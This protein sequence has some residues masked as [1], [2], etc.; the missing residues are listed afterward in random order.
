MHLVGFIIRRFNGPESGL[1]RNHNSTS[2]RSRKQTHSKLQLLGL[3][4]LEI[5][6]IRAPEEAELE[7]RCLRRTL[8]D[9]LASLETF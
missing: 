9:P 4:I 1:L 6:S 7:I 5:D 2:F 8:I 3:L